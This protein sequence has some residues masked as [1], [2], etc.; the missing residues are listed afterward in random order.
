MTPQQTALLTRLLSS[1]ARLARREGLTDQQL[2]EWMLD[3]AVRWLAA[4]G[5]SDNNLH[6]WVTHALQ[7]PR[8]LPLTAAARAPNDFGGRR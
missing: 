5:I 4:H 3:L 8:P 6:L 2:A 1:F 7:G